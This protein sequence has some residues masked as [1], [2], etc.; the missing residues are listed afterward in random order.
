[1]TAA[2]PPVDCS[3][4]GQPPYNC[5]GC[6]LS[7]RDL[8][9]KDLTGAQL[10][11]AILT[12]TS[13]N[14]VI[15]LAGADLTGAVMGNGTD[16][17]GCDLST[18]IFGPHP[19]F[20]SNAANPTTFA[21]ATIPYQTLGDTWSY[22]DLSGATIS[23]L[24]Q[25]LSRLEVLQCDLSG[26]DLADRTL[27]NAHFYG[28]TARQANFCGAVL[29][30]IVFT[31]GQTL[32]DLSGAHFAGAQLTEA[33]FDTSTL[34]GT[35]FS[36]A[37]L[38]SASFLQTRMDGTRFDGCDV[39]TC[40]FSAPPR[41]SI[42]PANL[43]SFRGARLNYAT[44]LKQWSYLDLTGATL[45]GLGPS[46]DLT[47]L[48]AVSAVLTGM[49][50]SGYTLDCCDLSAATLTGVRFS[51]ASMNQAV[52]A[53]VGNTCELFRVLGSSPDYAHFLSALQQD[54]VAGV[55]AVFA[56]YGRA[57]QTAQTSVK[58]DSPNRWWTVTDASTATVYSVTAASTDGPLIVLDSSLATRFDGAKLLHANFG[59][60]NN[61]RSQLR[62]SNFTDASLDNA[63]LSLVDLSQINPYNPA[64]ASTFSGASMNGV[65]LSQ[66]DLTGALLTGTV[67]LHGADLASVT[68]KNADLTGAQLGELA[69]AFRVP[70]SSGSD[71][72]NL[73][74]A[75]QA[76]NPAGVAAV[77]AAY[78]HPIA[79]GQT[80]VTVVVA[81]RSW[82][83]TEGTTQSIFTVLNWTSN[84]GLTFLVVS[85]PTQAATLTNAYLPGATLVDANLYGVSAAYAH[86]YGNVRLDGAILDQATLA[87][88]NLGGSSMIVKAL[89]RVDLSGANLV[90][91]TLK[92]ADLTQGVTLS[93]ANLQG[94]DLT[95]TELAGANL[96]NAAVAVPLTSTVAGVYLFG[97]AVSEPSW[98]AVV[99]ELQAATDQVNLTADG[100][101]R[102]IKA[103]IADLNNG[104]LHDLLPAFA[105][106]GVAFSGQATIEATSDPTAWQILDPAGVGNYTVWHGYDDLGE[107]GLLARP[108]LPALTEAFAANAAVAGT[109]RWQ[110]SVTPGTAANQ[111]LIDN[112]SE[113]PKNLQLGYA[114]VFVTQDT[115]RSL[116][117]YGTTL[118]IE[119][120]GDRNQLQIRTL[121]YNA[122]V[123]CPTDSTGTQSCHPDGSTSF[124]GPTTICP[125]NRTLL[126]NQESVPPV[127][128]THM[129]RSLAPPKP[130]T[131]V[132][133]PYGNCP[134]TTVSSVRMPD[135]VRRP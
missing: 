133:S 127:P 130:P 38:T 65:G 128:W 55:I 120:L 77:F 57:L 100:D 59:P 13:F 96:A 14:G 68:L 84:D 119:Q 23:G 39:T 94:T 76:Q 125:N 87:N 44:V 116:G 20:G 110:A 35:D 11:D 26:I 54:N 12:G 49:D 21:D 109:L 37:T 70:Q 36:S 29:D 106:C 92:G 80:T 33:V 6:D 98:S 52:L 18:T 15:S 22:L 24:P 122:T 101:Q 10:Q 99:A 121:T 88:A 16:F 3:L 32:C 85:I 28:V 105:R 53:G 27:K 107:E 67:Y 8:A 103:Y 81:N 25:D 2:S 108:S 79:A 69:E 41:F 1:M 30:N 60:D 104:D 56:T 114:T 90:N 111:W 93:Q 72:Q 97:I 34:T 86:L 78:Q 61:Q 7:G 64:T 131:C 46:V 83:V 19:N 102:T 5:Q 45:V 89:Y 9:G 135:P 129:L 115:D 58:T 118:R 51:Q 126:Q 113:N 31:R 4:S 63:D 62:G 91:S 50:L 73:L 17:S 47:Y 75:L 95:N 66:A 117:F 48:Q 40:F 132:P 124:F 134:Q 74:S 112:D 123:L 43:T 71:Y 42:D 82:T